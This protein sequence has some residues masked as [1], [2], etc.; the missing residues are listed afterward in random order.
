M[1]PGKVYGF[2]CPPFSSRVV[3]GDVSL[4]RLGG[5]CRDCGLLWTYVKPGSEG[6]LAAANEGAEKRLPHEPCAACGSLDVVFGNLL[7]SKGP[8]GFWPKVPLRHFFR[9]VD[10]FPI[11]DRAFA[12]R[13]CDIVT[14]RG[15]RVFLEKAGREFFDR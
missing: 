15:D 5:G 10:G 4:E 12:C 11:P 13:S 2:F 14:C 8:A 1:V 7:Q 6:P 3:F 9:M